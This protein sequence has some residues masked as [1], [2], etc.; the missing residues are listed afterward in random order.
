[1]MK[2]QLVIG[3]DIGGSHIASALVNLQTMD[4]ASDIVHTEVN[5]K[6]DADTIFTRWTQ[7]LK[8][9]VQKADTPIA[10]AFPG[11]FDYERGISWMKNVDKYD[12][13]YGMDICAELSRRLSPT[14]SFRFVNDAAA[15]ALGECVSGAAKSGHRVIVLT[16]GT[17]VGSCYVEDRKVITRGEGVPENGWVYCLPF[18]DGVVDEAF[19]T[20][21]FIKRY[22]ELSGIEVRGAKEIAVRYA[23][24][25]Q[26]RQL[27]QEYGERL[28]RFSSEIVKAFGADTLVI[29]GSIALSIDFF[30]SAMQGVFRS[31]GIRCP[32]L[33]AKLSQ[34]GAIIGAAS[35]WADRC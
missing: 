6:A 16:L 15:F 31:K 5:S 3:V 26:A 2:E 8:P 11:P 12:S 14:I 20:R 34:S 10:M 21:W 29:G 18:E 9:L 32:L 22:K 4:L 30:L 27:F 7:N 33:P 17:G 19:S 35:R 13:L 25:A 23:Q 1:M 24:D 28:G